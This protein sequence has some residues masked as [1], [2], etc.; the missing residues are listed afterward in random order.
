MRIS[1]FPCVSTPKNR[2]IGLRMLEVAGFNWEVG[3]TKNDLWTLVIVEEWFM[4]MDDKGQN[5]LTDVK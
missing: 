2:F 3:G 5:W 1:V 4:I